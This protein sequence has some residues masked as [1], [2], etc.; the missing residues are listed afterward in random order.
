M[1][2][3]AKLVTLGHQDFAKSFGSDLDPVT[4]AE[5]DKHD[6]SMIPVVG[7]ERDSLIVNIIDRIRNDNQIVG[8]PSRTEVWQIGWKENYDSYS[9]D[10]ET[11]NLL[12]K[13]IRAGKPI[14]WQGK[15]YVPSDPWFE[16]N[17][18]RVLRSHLFFRMTLA[19][20][21]KVLL[22]EFGAGTGWNLLH[23][24]EWFTDQNVDHELFASDFVD[25]AVELHT[26]LASRENLPL[27]SRIFDMKNPDYGYGISQPEQSVV[28]T[29]GALEQLAGEI[30]PM[31]DYLIAHQPRLVIHMEPA[32]EKYDLSTLEDYLA[33]WFQ[34]QRGYSSGLSSLLERKSLEGEIDLLENRRLGFGS[35]MMEGFNIFIWRPVCSR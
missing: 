27:S 8:H 1:E 12:P 11:K 15:F 23:A 2:S 10:A 28:L 19:V 4:L 3:D 20:T 7:A 18:T 31:I 29:M 5:I 22:H 26:E 21:G 14:R 30:V 25:S 33:S 34:G 24:H 35:Q 16:V 32:I 17:Y 13:F 9:Q 6:F